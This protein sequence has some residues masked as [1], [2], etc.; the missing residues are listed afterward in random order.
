MAELPFIT[1]YELRITDY[2]LRITDYELRITHYAP[3]TT[4]PICQGETMTETNKRNDEAQET[5]WEEPVFGD[6]SSD[7]PVFDE[8]VF[9]EP[10]FDEAPEGSSSSAEESAVLKQE[11]GAPVRVY[12][13]EDFDE[14]PFFEVVED[15]DA[16]TVVTLGKEN[17]A[18]STPAGGVVSLS[19]K[20]KRS[21]VKQPVDPDDNEMV[22]WEGSEKIAPPPRNRR[23]GRTAP[24]W[25]VVAGMAA[26][27][28]FAIWFG[29]FRGGG[30]DRDLT[31]TP[32]AAGVS[33]TTELPA[34]AEL[35]EPTPEAPV[36][37]PMP[38]LE[39]NQPVVVGNTGGQGIRLRSEPG[40]S[41][42]TLAIYQDG[43]RF[44]VL[45][46]DGDYDSYPVEL[47][48]YRW[49]RI[50]VDNPEENLTGW[51]AGNFLVT[52]EE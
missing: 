1:N 29:F 48:D 42:Q 36:P 24:F 52:V 50:Q 9:D 40:T 7:E 32:I 26:V 34:E 16:P 43:E 13:D 4:Q 39:V 6:E 2:G 51:A 10:V 25:L 18:R 23:L 41:G 46:P 33:G 8:P 11:D 14:E 49:Y 3:R 17:V 47:N 20:P 21:S 44:I 35:I 38:L 12:G 28:L 45:P 31:L 22:H 15:A 5:G 27:F 19:Q 30:E 37:T